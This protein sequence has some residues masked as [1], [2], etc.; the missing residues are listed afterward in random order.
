[1]LTDRRGDTIM[2]VIN[3]NT[4][5][6]DQHT[7]KFAG[8][9]NHQHDNEMNSDMR[10]LILFAARPDACPNDLAGRQVVAPKPQA[11][12]FVVAP[13][14]SVFPAPLSPSAHTAGG[15]KRSGS[16][17][18]GSAAK[19]TDDSIDTDNTPG[20]NKYND[21]S[22]QEDYDRSTIMGSFNNSGTGDTCGLVAANLSAYQDGELDSDE[23]RL[24]AAHV[25]KCPR[26]AEIFETLQQTDDEIEREW[27]ES[28][29][30]PSS[31]H[32]EQAID[33]VMAALPAIPVQAP[34]FAPRRVHARARWT[35]FASGIAAV[36]VLAVSLW[37]SY[38]L[39]YTRGRS[40]VA[41]ASPSSQPQSLSSQ[42]P[43]FLSPARKT[44]RFD[45]SRLFL[46][47]PAALRFAP[48][49]LFV[50]PAPLTMPAPASF[51]LNAFP[52]SFASYASI[53][54]RSPLRHS[55]TCP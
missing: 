36:T 16:R 45:S 43:Q 25:G 5:D 49:I 37:S 18:A 42:H 15:D 4:N 10:D 46:L 19:R 17:V 34:T 54:P 51:S 52:A 30:L 21:H 47:T 13:A 22:E 27:R 38:Q 14:V 35:R 23:T 28:A 6:N 12:D 53:L 29:P 11:G 55:Q 31:L 41:N 1:M 2:F 50:H 3:L 8:Q 24:V 32:Y 26:C 48:A 44:A 33:S 9:Y 20:D 40:S 39:G 7:G